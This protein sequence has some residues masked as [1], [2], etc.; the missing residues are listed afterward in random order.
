MPT[1]AQKQESKRKL[2]RKKLGKQPIQA[3][4]DR[5]AQSAMKFDKECSDL[6]S[7]LCQLAP[8]SLVK[9]LSDNLVVADMVIFGFFNGNPLRVSSTQIHGWG[10]KNFPQFFAAMRE[11]RTNWRGIIQVE[12]L[13]QDLIL[14]FKLADD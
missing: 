6:I 12:I 1:E 9:F 7:S 4:H 3:Y 13:E 8:K 10:F 5:K 14:D 11:L 2:L